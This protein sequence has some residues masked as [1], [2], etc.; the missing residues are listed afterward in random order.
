MI[1]LRNFAMKSDA[2][3]SYSKRYSRLSL[4]WERLALQISQHRCTVIVQT[5]SKQKTAYLTYIQRECHQQFHWIWTYRDWILSQAVIPPVMPFASMLLLL[6][7]PPTQQRTSPTAGPS[8]CNSLPDP[9][10]KTAIQT[11]P[12]LLSVACWRHFCLH[13]TSEP[14]ILGDA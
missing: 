3:V 13:G 4:L 10:R 7:V 5:I 9:V 12:K 11:P 8:A 14:R 1:C 2:N 6:H